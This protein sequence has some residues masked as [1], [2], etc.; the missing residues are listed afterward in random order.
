MTIVFRLIILF[1]VAGSI[2]MQAKASGKIPVID[3]HTH[4]SGHPSTS[5]QERL[6]INRERVAK[7]AL[8][9]MDNN[10]VRLS[11]IMPTPTINGKLN[12][13]SL[14]EQ[15]RKHPGRFA[16]LGG[17]AMLNPII[18]NTP[19]DKVTSAKKKIFE[20]RAESILRGGAIGFGEMAGLHFSYFEKHPFE[21]S[22]PDHPLFLLL[23]DIAARHD[24]P[25]DLH[26]E[27]VVKEIPVPE[28]LRIQ[29][30][31]NPARIGPNVAA[32]ERL[33]SYN[34]K[35][36]VILDHS[37]DSTGHRTAAII[38]GLMQRHSNLYMSLNVIPGFL[39]SENL[40]L[41]A[42]GKI[43]SD[44][45]ALIEEFPDR[46]LI[47]SDQFYYEKE[48]KRM[49]ACR[50]NC[51]AGD[52]VGPSQRWLKF[53]TPATA[54]KVAYANAE[55]VFRLNDKPSAVSESDNQTEASELSSSKAQGEPNVTSIVVGNTLKFIA[56]KNGKET[57]IYFAQNGIAVVVLSD[58][59]GN[60]IR[61]KWFVNQNGLLC[62]TVGKQ[63]NEHCTYVEIMN[64]N[65]RVIL[66]NEE[67]SYQAILLKGKQLPGQQ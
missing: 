29:S 44:W 31:K 64:T 18:Q 30:S 8:Q 50:P 61:K 54:E 23:A 4:L 36:R 55:R 66:S 62:R 27:L 51:D 47:G 12:Y 40:P 57:S 16:V 67:V 49:N 19:P 34:T 37:V 33:L 39:F 46:F 13:E 26:H 56:P 11:I 9:E 1:L 59:P 24:V 52:H 5:M 53:L 41:R 7:L 17:G 48:K 63:D 60:K 15:S 42:S 21:N 58:R 28:K 35:T 45:K 20:E 38:R 43:D 25:I 14:V 10:N 65:D 6:A 2:F 22:P 3:V 32:L